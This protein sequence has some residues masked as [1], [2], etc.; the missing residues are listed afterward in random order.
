LRL[1]DS[2][3]SRVVLGSSG[4]MAASQRCLTAALLLLMTVPQPLLLPLLLLLLLVSLHRVPRSLCIV[5]DNETGSMSIPAGDWPRLSGGLMQETA[6]TCEG[7]GR[8]ARGW[9]RVG[10]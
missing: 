2:W 7:G 3:P 6:L 9:G 10:V 8:C 4:S 5:I 1:Y